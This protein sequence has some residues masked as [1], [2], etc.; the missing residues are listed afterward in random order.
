MEGAPELPGTGD[1]AALK[2]HKRFSV[3]RSPTSPSALARRADGILI[4][5]VVVRM[6]LARRGDADSAYELVGDADRWTITFNVVHTPAGDETYVLAGARWLPATAQAI[7]NLRLLALVDRWD[8][9][10]RHD[11]LTDRL[12][13]AFAVP[14]GQAVEESG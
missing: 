4:S 6:A 5:A 8:E 12:R 2:V 14:A 7:V 1:L 11:G 13:T 10:W 9:F 3:V